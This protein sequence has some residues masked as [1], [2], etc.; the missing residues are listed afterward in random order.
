MLVM[1]DS[2]NKRPHVYNMLDPKTYLGFCVPCFLVVLGEFCPTSSVPYKHLND[3]FFK[4]ENLSLYNIIHESVKKVH[5]YSKVIIY[6][7]IKLRFRK[8]QHKQIKKRDNED[9]VPSA[10]TWTM[11]A[12]TCR[13]LKHIIFLSVKQ[14]KF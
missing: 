3:W 13:D 9:D 12:L 4:T 2:S 11:Q 1:L 14:Y 5:I 7:G 6:A 10:W 8:V